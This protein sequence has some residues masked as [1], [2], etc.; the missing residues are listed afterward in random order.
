MQRPLSFV[1]Q[2]N[3]KLEI[4]PDVVNI[5]K[6]SHNP[7]LLLVYGKTRLGKSTT[8]N[9]IIKGN[10][11]SW[12]YVNNSPFKAQR[13]RESLTVGCD[14]F[15]PIKCSE[16]MKRHSINEIIKEDYDIFFCDSEGLSSV[17]EQSKMLIPG[18]L[19]LL[20]TCT[21]SVLMT[22][23]VP[24]QN[25]IEDITSEIQFSKILQK[26]NPE[27][28]S[29]Q[30]LIY[31]SEFQVDFQDAKDFQS[32]LKI[33]KDEVAIAKQKILKMINQYYKHL[34]VTENDFE[35]IA[36]GPYNKY[37]NDEPDHKDI[38][39]LLYWDSIHNIIKAMVTC[40]G[41]IKVP[42]YSGEKLTYLMNIV[43]DI[44]KNYGE[45]PRNND[46]VNMLT[47]YVT[48]LFNQYSKKEFD[49]IIS[50]IRTNIK[51]NYEKYYQILDNNKAKNALSSCIDKNLIDVF[52]SLIP[53]KMNDFLEKAAVIVQKEIKDQIDIEYTKIREYI[54]SEKYINDAISNIKME[55]DNV[56]FKEDINS[57][58]V[59]NYGIYWEAI[60]KKNDKL[61]LYF[62][63]YKPEE[64]EMLKNHF[65][66][67]IRQKLQNL[68]IKK[69][70]WKNYFE[71]LQLKINT[72]VS[73]EY[74]KANKPVQY[75]E[76]FD[77]MIK[78]NQLYNQILI[79]LGNE[80]K[81][82]YL[83]ENRKNIVIKYIQDIC[84]NEYST[85]QENSKKLQKFHDINN[86]IMTMVDQMIRNYMDR[87]FVGRNMRDEIN[88]QWGF[89]EVIRK[90]INIDGF[91]SRQN[92]PEENKKI[93]EQ[94]I[95][96]LLIGASYNFLKNIAN[97]PLK[98]QVLSDLDK[99]CN[100]LAKNKMEELLKGVNYIEDKK[101]FTH[102]QFFTLFL[103]N[104][105]I[106][107]NQF[108]NREE[109]MERL[110]EIS[111]KKEIEYNNLLNQLKPNWEN[112]IKNIEKNLDEKLKIF[113]KGFLSNKANNDKSKIEE[114]KWNEFIE[115]L[116]LF[117][118]I[119]ES[120]H[121]EIKKMINQ[122]KEKLDFKI[123]YGNKNKMIL[124]YKKPSL[125]NGYY[126]YRLLGEQF[127][128]NNSNKCKIIIN[129]K[130]KELFETIS[131]TQEENPINYLEVTLIEIIT[132]T[133][134]K[135]LFNG[136]NDLEFVQSEWDTSNVQNMEFMFDYCRNLTELK[137][138]KQWNTSKVINMYGLFSNCE[139]LK[140]LPNI[141]SW[142]LSNV[143]SIYGMFENCSNLSYIPDISGWNIKNLRDIHHLFSGCR[144]LKKV[145]ELFQV[146]SRM[147]SITGFF[148]GC[149]S[150]T[151][152]PDISNWNTENIST[153]IGVFAYCS[154][155]TYLPDIS[156]W[157]INKATDIGRMFEGCSSLIEI[158]NIGKWNNIQNADDIFK[159]CLSLKKLPDTSNWESKMGFDKY[160][161]IFN[162][163]K[164]DLVPVKY[165]E[166]TNDQNKNL[167]K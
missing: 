102:E 163:C 134:M 127:V 149:S 80:L 78:H 56:M 59:N 166:K 135:S 61:F 112:T 38:N 84:N 81:L 15:G 27:L 99:E 152:L 153:A 151:Y 105:N 142:D 30:M 44:F 35:I 49:K 36:G 164:E 11:D 143:T 73:L 156:K 104:E 5:I 165:R 91:L 120:K 160:K 28:K 53:D 158:P 110:R 83:S 39:A 148:W 88:E 60:L 7:K 21:I 8:L 114:E 124:K 118:G 132:V 131:L 90:N 74:Q 16:I 119:E 43:F 103:T 93:I 117:D 109:I 85:L 108:E 101:P 116:K 2:A 155:L 63:N 18:I 52:S 92:L 33:Y 137:C 4:N 113:E 12:K 95:D 6:K 67:I 76:D 71:E 126:T 24:D 77:K 57:Q 111:K 41:N 45:I 136:C 141:S 87:I 1:N 37:F 22:N 17:D 145:P 40:L 32:C 121:S 31:I 128:K 157:N 129:G 125:K 115:P 65:N 161:R 139:S 89:P 42:Q 123:K 19:T 51:Y 79:E 14:I 106:N 100:T 48:N 167:K 130:E 72:K 46:L 96:K 122:K 29:P 10:I 94:N 20:P 3:G 133:N 86:N 147:E 34:N 70:S 54:L 144:S 162:G 82:N 75:Q 146:N 150:L 140:E 50:D 107:L 68:I 66:G 62:Y 159:G 47:K 98:D 26:M 23:N 69:I 58:M 13:R 64:I 9:Q 55:I 154:K 138:I 97:L 25:T